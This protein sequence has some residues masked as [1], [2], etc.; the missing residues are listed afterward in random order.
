MAK[1]LKC[2]I[3]GVLYKPYD[4][5]EIEIEP[6]DIT[7]FDL[8]ILQCAGKYVTRGRYIDCCPDCAKAIAKV[9]EERKGG[10]HVCTDD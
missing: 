2:D 1:A 6:D 9:I 5:V 7:T 8:I 4:G 3:C 10:Q